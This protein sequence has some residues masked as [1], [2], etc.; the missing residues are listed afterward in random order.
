[1]YSGSTAAGVPS[2]L[3]SMGPPQN[4]GINLNLDIARSLR[5]RRRLAIAVGILVLIFLVFV[6]L[7]RKPY[8]KATALIYVQPIVEKTAT[9]PA[10]SYDPGRYDAYMDQQLLTI[11]RT[12]ILGYALDQLPP[13]I[14]ATFSPEKAVAIKQLDGGLLVERLSGSYEISV[15]MGRG[16]PYTVA[17]IANA[18]AAAYLENGQRDDLALSEQQR[19][20]LE[21]ERQR[22]QDE[23]EKDRQEQ[24]GLSGALGV[25]DTAGD[26]ANP[27]DSHLADLRSQLGE[28]HNAHVAAETQL[29]AL[30]NKSQSSADLDAAADSLTRSDT[31][32]S[33]MKSNLGGERGALI[34]EMKG[35]TPE[36]P[37]YTRDQAKLDAL[38]EQ[39]NSYTN[40][41]K[42]KSGQT[43]E[44]QLALE[45]RRTGDMEAKLEADLARQTAIAT[46][47]TPKLQQAQDLAESIKLLQARY[48]DVDNAIHSISLAQS[49]NFAAHTSLEATQ[50]TGPQPS[51]KILILALAL[52][53]AIVCGV[54]AAILRQMLDF[55]VYIGADV[56]RVLSF[57]PMAVLPASEEV[58]YQVAEEFLFRLVAGLDQAHRVGGASTFIF[59]PASQDT[60]FDDLISSVA[61]ELELL[62]YRTM[63]LS[64]AE[65][66]SPIE[67]TG[68]KPY[69]EWKDS[70]ALTRPTNETGLR[71]RRE[72]LI[73]EHLERLK[74]K[75]DFLFIKAGPLRSSSE[76]EFVVRL[77]DVAVLIAESGKTT[78]RE[79]RSCLSLIKRLRARGLAA[80]LI[81][82]KLRNAD[83]DF[84][85]SVRFASSQSS[86][87]RVKVVGDGMLTVGRS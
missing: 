73:D 87:S 42:H 50:P 1:M 83:N 7:T 30:K 21:Q 3:N 55:H 15:S 64:A 25:A 69:S 51:K 74:Q 84:L 8:Y 31:E 34:L 37:D 6:G 36:N 79:L 47:D 10:G 72:S 80:L 45:A 58:G 46:A 53:L 82:L 65:A 4:E 32:L 62:G 28:A 26:N 81:D 13:A 9:D 66:L 5:M 86:R 22:I 39:I 61:A 2:D 12:D 41:V 29:S 27:Y 40:E 20:S 59:S 11:E 70:T 23:I 18:V 49:P 19:V 60:S 24:A 75:V 56:D 44:Q 52:P 78:R 63:T 35:L 38:N 77:G 76:S 85:E 17:P 54:A 68:K 48:A 14:R 43:Y 57:S 67:V 16:E 33:A 71:V